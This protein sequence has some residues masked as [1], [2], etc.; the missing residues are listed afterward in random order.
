MNPPSSDSGE[1][2]GTPGYPLDSS[3]EAADPG[4]LVGVITAGDGDIGAGNAG[5]LRDAATDH[6]V[7]LVSHELK[8]PLTTLLLHLDRLLERVTAQDAQGTLILGDAMRR[9][10][11]RQARIVNDLFDLSRMR[12][13]KLTLDLVMVDLDTIVRSIASEVALR[14]PDRQLHLKLGDPSSPRWCM[15]DPVR[16]EQMVSNLLDNA[17][18]F[19]APGGRIEVGVASIG[20][21]ARVSV[22]DDGCGISAEFLPHVF[23]MFGQE[24]LVDADANSGMGIGLALVEELAK[25]HGGS[26][27][28]HSRGARCGARFTVWL[29]LLSQASG[30]R[31]TASQRWVPS[32]PAAKAATAESATTLADGVKA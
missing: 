9:S 5:A 22:T 11:R 14:A 3:D 4:A 23:R 18:K 29:P 10:I 27:E 1:A 19:G 8:Q 13:G 21:L 32:S 7:A 15:A 31:S 26:V 17:V 16:L 24:R 28:V 12:T 25:A 30:C 6:Y 2:Q 20:S